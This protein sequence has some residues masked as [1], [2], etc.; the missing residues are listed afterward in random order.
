MF[1][2]KLR[3][4]FSC[5][6]NSLTIRILGVCNGRYG[7]DPEILSEP[8]HS[9][10][11]LLSLHAIPMMTGLLGGWRGRHRCLGVVVVCVCGGEGGVHTSH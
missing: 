1:E 6:S 11:F 2:A 7:G 3:S 4:P 8:G 10:V 9:W 5:H